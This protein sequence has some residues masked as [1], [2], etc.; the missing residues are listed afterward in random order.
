MEDG[1]YMKAYEKYYLIQL[2]DNSCYEPLM[3]DIDEESGDFKYACEQ[4]ISHH[5][6]IQQTRESLIN[7][8]DIKDS[9]TMYTPLLECLKIAKIEH[10]M[11]VL[12]ALEEILFD[13][14]LYTMEKGLENGSITE[15]DICWNPEEQMSEERDI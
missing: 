14:I 10:A 6:F 12:N 5:E 2:M 1:Y 15:K 7:G 8:E 11:F 3:E 9:N 4:L 13:R